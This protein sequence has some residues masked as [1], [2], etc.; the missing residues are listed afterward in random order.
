MHY[1][2]TPI[3]TYRDLGK[4]AGVVE[5]VDTLDLGSSAARCESSSLSACTTKA[6]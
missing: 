3:I 2:C 4:Y 5:L 1:I 6:S